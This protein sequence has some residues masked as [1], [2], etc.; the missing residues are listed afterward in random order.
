MGLKG[1]TNNTMY[2]TVDLGDIGGTVS[3]IP[4]S[5]LAQYVVTLLIPHSFSFVEFV[6]QIVIKT[7][8]D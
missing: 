5:T 3:T 4:L 7:R 6:L 1:V 2:Q 8:D